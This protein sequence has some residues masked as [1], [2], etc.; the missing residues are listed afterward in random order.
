MMYEYVSAALQGRESQLLAR[1]S[2]ARCQCV[3]E[4][5]RYTALTYYPVGPC[6]I[7]NMGIRSH[8]KSGNYGSIVGCLPDGRSMNPPV[9]S[10]GK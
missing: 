8:R 5:E 9:G 7:K 4:R 2:G 3:K 6:F 1:V 10:S